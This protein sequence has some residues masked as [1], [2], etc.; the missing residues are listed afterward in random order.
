MN[1]QDP[2]DAS[3]CSSC[4]DH[5]VEFAHDE[6]SDDSRVFVSTHLAACGECALAYCRLRA[7]L[8]GISAAVD[9]PVPAALRAKVR[10]R[11]LRTLRPPWWRRIG[12]VC[13]RPVPAYG[14]V[15]LALLPV[16]LWLTP[17]SP[18]GGSTQ[19]TDATSSASGPALGSE[20]RFKADA[21]SPSKPHVL[22]SDYDAVLVSSAPGDLY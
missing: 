10:R 3:P 8:G 21:A 16:L 5:L 11:V 6:V 7:D 19:A 14:A 4:R 17:G 13:A 15:A 1:T 22:V 9:R 12:A 20:N 2:G 18:G